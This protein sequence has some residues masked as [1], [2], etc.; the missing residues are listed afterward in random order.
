MSFMKNTGRQAA[1]ALL[2]AAALLAVSLSVPAF[3]AEGD[4]DRGVAYLQ[5]GK[6]AEA[7]GIFESLIERDAGDPYL[8]YHLGLAYYRSGK[9]GRAFDAFSKVESLAGKGAQE[10]F[11]LGVAFYNVGVAYF[12]DRS[13]EE[14]RPCFE[15]ALRLDPDDGDSRYYMGLTEVETGQYEKAVAD[16]EAAAKV[17][18]G[19]DK[20][21]AA[22]RNAAGMAYYRQG[23][24]ARA[25][26]EFART[27]SLDPD[28][29]EALYYLGLINY[30][31]NGYAA[32]RPYFEKIAARGAPEGPARDELFTTFFN[33]GVDFQNRDMSRA[34]SEMFGKAA[35]LKPS[36][37]DAHYYMG[38]NLM[39]LER[40]E[41]AASE[42]RQ[43]LALA[44][45]MTRAKSKLDVAGRFAAEKAAGEA[46]EAAG[47]S[48]WHRALA[49]YTKAVS[50][51]PS[52]RE[53]RKGLTAATEA[54]EKD[55][56]DRIAKVNAHLSSG[57]YTAAVEAAR[58]LA[59]LNPGS[60][61]AGALERETA[62]RLDQ[63]AKDTIAKA[64]A[65]EGREA[66]GEAA[67][68]YDRA[69]VLNPSDR[70]SSSSAARLRA[71]IQDERAK[72]AKAFD[73]GRL[74][75]A[76]KSYGT[77][78]RYVPEDA[79]ARAG[80]DA[81]DGRIAAETARL[82]DE[83]DAALGS[84]DLAKAASLASAA[85]ELSPEDAGALQLKKKVADRT[86][87]AVARLVKDGEGQLSSGDREKAVASFKAALRLDPDNQAARRGIDRAAS[88]P[89]EPAG[90][91]EE[92][93]RWYLSGVE[94]YTKGELEEAIAAWREALR[95][96][97]YNEKAKS[98]IE[99]AQ[100]KLGQ[101]AGKGPG[102]K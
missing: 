78:L 38:Y 68:L 43:A 31:E 99:K 52:S 79:D 89:H 47:N 66:L 22:I 70:A 24:A 82:K 53:A 74:A 40:Y 45:D 42:F 3:A 91:E 88:V 18:E 81:V 65:A 72:A 49:L 48:E 90:D 29:I 93:R 92:V 69:A 28:N 44:P 21:L 39:A 94:H 9:H 6:T 97:P 26:E 61:E 95:L 33:M 12:R 27:L 35:A 63:A 34:A 2:V 5:A 59:K 67:S 11:R 46:K 23:A 41:E 84:G 15:R 13:Y 71:R 25:V 57:D 1:P 19:D 77:L 64:K 51:D 7:L 98:G 73:E 87:D 30:K 60:A 76:R 20:A 8:Y 32:A 85:V 62:S 36:D 75:D 50:L 83:A 37:P 56:K 4:Y 54:V 100:E 101:P 14:A 102:V 96:D 17:K 10:E 80:G 86:R 58:E 16:L 55:T